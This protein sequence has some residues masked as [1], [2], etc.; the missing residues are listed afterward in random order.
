MDKIR[1][2]STMLVKPFIK[3]FLYKIIILQGRIG[4]ADTIDLIALSG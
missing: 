2:A 4:F 1:I 3:V